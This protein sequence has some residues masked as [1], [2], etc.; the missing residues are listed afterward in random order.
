MCA[1][2]KVGQLE[3]HWIVQ[4]S[5]EGALV[6]A[7]DVDG[8]VAN[9]ANDLDTCCRLEIGPEVQLHVLNRVDS[10]A[11]DAVVGYQL[12]DPVVVLGADRGQ[13]GVHVWQRVTGGAQVAENE[14]GCVVFIL[15]LAEGMEVAGGVERIHSGVV[16]CADVAVVAHMVCDD[17]DH[18]EHSSRVERC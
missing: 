2:E 7:G 3:V 13:S 17:I 12:L 16:Y 8:A 9:L 11:V 18:Q 6:G 1:V 5:I 10:Q 4:D 15:D 14:L